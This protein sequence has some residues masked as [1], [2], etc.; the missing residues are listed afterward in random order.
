VKEYINNNFK[1]KENN[2]KHSNKSVYL[3]NYHMVW[4]PKYR[5]KILTGEIKERLEKILKEVA[6]NKR[7]DILSLQ[8][9]PD[10]VH[11]FVSANMDIAPS[12]IAKS[13]KGRSS[14]VL[15]KEFP[16]LLKMPTLWTRAYFMSTAGNVSSKTIQKYIEEQ[17][18]K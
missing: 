17:W 10:H 11:L 5:R 8:I 6:C 9:M 13:V 3:C 16:Q 15:R 14:N 4:C 12:Q 18:K 2:Y 7:F 1:F